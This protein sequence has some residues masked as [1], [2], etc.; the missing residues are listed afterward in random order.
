[1]VAC[2]K[3]CYKEMTHFTRPHNRDSETAY[4]SLNGKVCWFK[5]DITISQGT[6]QCGGQ[7]TFG[8]W[9]EAVF[10]VTGCSVTPS[11]SG[12]KPITV[13]VWTSLD[14]R[15]AKD[16]SFGI[17]NVVIQNHEPSRSNRTRCALK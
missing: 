8:P 11:G 2:T 7:G 14:A 13:R 1:M 5:T 16:E 9:N 6:Q 17:A 3:G 12:Y 10:P 4:V 15:D